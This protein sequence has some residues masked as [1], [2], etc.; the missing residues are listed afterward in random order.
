MATKVFGSHD[1]TTLTADDYYIE[2]YKLIGDRFP[3]SLKVING[4]ITGASYETEW[5]EG[6]TTPVDTG[7]VDDTGNP[8]IDYKENYT[9]KKLSKEQTKK[10]DSYL[11]KNIQE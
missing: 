1:E 5:K 4:K 3:L 8:I 7:K 6:T 2:I 10:L 9:T 11:E